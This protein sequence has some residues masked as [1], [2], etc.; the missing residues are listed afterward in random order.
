VFCEAAFFTILLE[1]G[2]AEIFRSFTRCT[3][4]ATKIKHLKFLKSQ[5]AAHVT[6]QPTACF[7]A[8]IISLNPSVDDS[9]VPSVHYRYSKD[10]GDNV[11]V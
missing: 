7:Q 10:N 1:I 6:I 9:S 2:C 4:R 3:L 11:H 5:T 8:F